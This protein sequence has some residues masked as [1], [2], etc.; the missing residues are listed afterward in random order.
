MDPQSIIVDSS[1]HEAEPERHK[2]QLESQLRDIISLLLSTTA[3][4]NFCEVLLRIYQPVFASLVFGLVYFACY[5]RAQ[6][7]HQ[8]LKGSQ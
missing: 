8:I 5:Q 7:V 3:Y 4:Q 6:P 1:T 2:Y